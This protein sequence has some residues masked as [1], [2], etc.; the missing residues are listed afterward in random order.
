MINFEKM[1]KEHEKL[2]PQADLTSQCLKA[3]EE[4]R[5]FKSAKGTAQVVKELA[6]VAICCIGIY[7][8]D[9]D[10]AEY[11]YMTAMSYADTL[12]LRSS[13][14]EE[15]NRKWDINTKRKWVFKNGVY[16]HVGID[17]NE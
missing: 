1:A 11:I 12:G 6:D 10:I 17:G 14:E 16:K 15:V 13:I 3:G 9:R 5:E 2:F 4:I 7:R 8:F